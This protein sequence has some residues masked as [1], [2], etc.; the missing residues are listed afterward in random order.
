V[1]QVAL[2]LQ[3]AGT[4]QVG[5]GYPRTAE[6]IV[7]DDRDVVRDDLAVLD[8]KDVERSLEL[9]PR[10][11]EWHCQTAAAPAMDRR[12]ACREIREGHLVY[13]R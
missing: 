2:R 11:E 3:L 10:E 4:A 7:T 1:N 5:F 8:G 13:E 12:G 9:I 6:R